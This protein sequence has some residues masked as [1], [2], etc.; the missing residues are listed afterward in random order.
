M[1]GTASPLAVA[2]P[3]G[4]GCHRMPTA[5]TPTNSMTTTAEQPDR[6]GRRAG[7]RRADA[8]RGRGRIPQLSR[9][10]ARPRPRPVTWAGAG[11]A[12]LIPCQRA[13]RRARVRRTAIA[14]YPDQHEPG[15]RSGEPP[16]RE[17]A[18]LLAR[19]L[20]D[21]AAWAIPEHITAAVTDSPWVLPRQ[22]FARRADAY[23]AQPGG[24]SFE[25]AWAALDP[26][27]SVLDV[28]CGAGAACLPLLP[29]ATLLTVHGRWPQVA[30]DVPPADVV[31][32]HHV[33]Y[34]VAEIEPF[35]A[36]LTSHARR[37]VVAEITAAHP[38]SS[39]NQLWL[40]FHGLRRPERP[41]ADDL[42][43]I[44]AALG[45]EAGHARW[46]RPEGP[47]YAS[48]AELVDVTRR[49]LCLPPGR[50]GEVAAALTDLGVDPA[51][52]RDLG[53]S[54]RDVVTIWWKG[55]AARD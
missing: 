8:S 40:R 1:T 49:R 10:A 35:T 18:A 2:R 6:C 32:C 47:D 7:R 37:L 21:L 25:R 5:G 9:R 24:P 36:A 51:H 34:N 20:E 12:T 19:W 11:P 42:L 53:S 15:A 14:T 52:P 13:G 54:G 33:L 41:T 31:T 27:G 3:P 50:A 22:V 48:F 30:A 45:I 38:L 16:P 29:R 55:H 46:R 44:L 43:A 28:G 23:A 39:L 4:T 26:P 17:A